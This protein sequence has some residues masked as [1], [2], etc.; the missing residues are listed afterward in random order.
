[1]NSKKLREAIENYNKDQTNQG[2]LAIIDR[3]LGTLKVI[4]RKSDGKI[5]ADETIDSAQFAIDNNL[6]EETGCVGVADLRTKPAAVTELDPITQV[7]LRKGKTTVG[8]PQVDWNGVSMELRFG[9]AFAKETGQLPEGGS[10]MA[11]YSLKQPALQPPWT[12]II[13]DAQK[14]RAKVTKERAAQMAGQPVTD[15]ATPAERALFDRCMARIAKQVSPQVSSTPVPQPPAPRPPAP[16]YPPPSGPV[17]ALP[18]SSS[19]TMA[20][21]TA[22]APQPGAALRGPAPAQAPAGEERPILLIMAASE[23]KNR[24][25]ALERHC[26]PLRGS[27]VQLDGCPPGHEPDAWLNGQFR[28]GSALVVLVTP[29]LLA[30]DYLMAKVQQFRALGKPLFPFIARPCIWENTL[31][32]EIQPINPDGDPETYRAASALNGLIASLP[33]H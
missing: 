32:G 18:P 22:P 5:D 31:F 10:R 16:L 28:R 26:R 9:A 19:G 27:R 3:E 30:N 24:A 25:T 4:H 11:A 33:T 7:P 12:F 8:D 29:D 15:P 14:L 2:A 20:W 21:N 17:V 1:M 23:D 6:T 13:E